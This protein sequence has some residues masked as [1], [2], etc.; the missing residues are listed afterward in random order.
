MKRLLVALLLGMWLLAAGTGVAQAMPKLDFFGLFDHHGAVMLVIDADT[1]VIVFANLAAHAYYG[2]PGTELVGMNINQIN[3]LSPEEVAR[4]CQAAAR[5]ERNF[6]IFRHR[7][8]AGSIRTVEVRSYPVLL[9]GETYLYSI[10]TDISDELA[11]AA[12]H[13]RNTRLII[14]MLGFV[15]LVLGITGVILLKSARREAFHRRL[16]AE[17]ERKYRGM[18][19]NV[20]GMVYRCK[21]DREWTMEF[22]SR[23]CVELTGYEP[24]ELLGNGDR[25]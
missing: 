2:F 22:L 5:E 4:E 17:G 7:L 14:V 10:V 19:A 1:G 25:L 20:P 24:N 3:T 13:A 23:G 6:F 15:M 12:S 16:F 18:I 11:L 9:Q 8:H 21:F